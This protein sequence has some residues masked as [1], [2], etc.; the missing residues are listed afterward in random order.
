MALSI[1]VGVGSKIDIAGHILQVK[2]LV[3]PNLIV[4][5]VD[6]GE[7]VVISDQKA[8]ELLPGVRVQTGVGPGGSGNRLAFTADRAIRISRMEDRR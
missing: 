2:S 5:S 1:G 4:V 8:V 6:Q 3:H 7:E